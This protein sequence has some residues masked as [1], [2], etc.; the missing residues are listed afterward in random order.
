MGSSLSGR[1]TMGS[2]PSRRST[3]GSQAL[4]GQL[5]TLQALDDGLLP[6]PALDGGLLPAMLDRLRYRPHRR[7]RGSLHDRRWR[8]FRA[9]G[10]EGERG[11]LDLHVAE[12]S[13][14]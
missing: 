7:P 8:P 4:D 13:A 11:G 14:T 1:S 2:R 12:F 10:C 6:L 5:P 9:G 3:T